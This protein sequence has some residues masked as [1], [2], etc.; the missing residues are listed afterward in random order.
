ML[1][2]W[3]TVDA[4]NDHNVY[5][6]EAGFNQWTRRSRGREVRGLPAVRRTVGQRGKTC[7][8]FWLLV[9]V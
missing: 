7:R 3:L 5:L 4:A 8:S 1:S 9:I 2:T 6:D